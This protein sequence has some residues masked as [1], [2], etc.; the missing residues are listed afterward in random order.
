MEV[1]EE[2]TPIDSVNPEQQDDT[3][4][5]PS[6]DDSRKDSFVS[7]GS[8]SAKSI[9]EGPIA[10]SD[11]TPNDP[12]SNENNSSDSNSNDKKMIS[13]E[14]AQKMLTKMK[15]LQADNK[16]SKLRIEKLENDLKEITN[17]KDIREKQ[18][19]EKSSQISMFQ[20]DINNALEH[21]E[22]VNEANSKYEQKIKENEELINTLKKE[23][24]QIS[25]L[26]TD[27]S[28][29]QEKVSELMEE[30]LSLSKKQGNYENTIRSL[31]S[32]VKTLTDENEELKTKSTQ[33]MNSLDIANK[34]INELEDNKKKLTQST[35]VHSSQLTEIQKQY[36]ELKKQYELLKISQDRFVNENEVL[37]KE[38]NMENTQYLNAQKQL[39][40]ITA[41]YNTLN[42][43]MQGYEEN[44]TKARDAY[45]QCQ[46]IASEKEKD[47]N[48]Y[49]TK[50][51]K[52]KQEL[53]S[54][55]QIVQN[56]LL[57]STTTNLTDINS[58]KQKTLKVLEK[59]N[60]L[61]T[62]LSVLQQEYD[63]EKKKNQDIS[64]KYLDQ[65]NDKD[66][67]IGLLLLLLLLLLFFFF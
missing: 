51:E 33:D 53:Q 26:K 34:R 49:I 47:L 15:I 20:T 59:Y 52:D 40:E 42:S 10:P 28:D 14:T 61:K 8:F 64:N 17:L 38:K 67:Y 4:Q 37:K 36:E 55:I 56:Q 18:L 27:L 11:I 7:I 30:G 12:T 13:S 35:D 63:I 24:D 3:I 45:T 22:Q 50:L 23:N 41:K 29:A 46:E 31:K 65:L 58:E 9:S 66:V 44:L 60:Q 21:L 39:K 62:D 16:K 19:E 32:K 5:F 43:T 54:K 48:S 1:P 57:S 2:T 6:I 25:Q